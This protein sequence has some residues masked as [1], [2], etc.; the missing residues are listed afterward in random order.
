MSVESK[1]RAVTTLRLKEMKD[2]GEKIAMLTSYDY[3]M[4]RIVDAAGV[5]VILVGDS[6][7][8][9]MAGYETTLPI[10]LDAMIYHAR[11]VVRAVERA[12][13][14][15]DLPFG[16]Y[17]G[18]SKIALDSAIRIMKETEADAVKIEGGE[19]ILESVER[20]LTAGIPIMGHLGLTP[21]SIHKFGTY[22]VRAKEEAEAEKLVRD[23][24][25]LEE[26]GCFSV[27][28]EKIPALLAERV[29]KELSIPT[30]GIGAGGA[31]DGQVLVIHDMLGIN[32]GFSPRFLRR[33]ADLHT[34]M[35]EAVKSY[36]GDVKSQDF[37]NEQEQY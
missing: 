22:N 23:A 17:Q 27:V 26:A 34:V 31:T 20:I 7:A 9:V 29:S 37:P 8:N 14:V 4:A 33:Y 18:N 32:K 10:T 6:A 5:D 30:I 28:L 21:Q 1:V 15:V 36:V 12:L 13:V 19:E 11:A 3:S 2:R 24:H 35:T 16:T 25:L